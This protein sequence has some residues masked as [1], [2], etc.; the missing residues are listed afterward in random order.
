MA[1]GY[2][3]EYRGFYREGAGDRWEAV[4]TICFGLYNIL[5]SWRQGG[6]GGI[7][8]ALN[9][10]STIEDAVAAIIMW[11]HLDDLLMAGNFNANLSDP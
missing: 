5:T 9:N 8:C 7:L 4:R 11:P 1:V 6:S 2:V 10:A 3:P